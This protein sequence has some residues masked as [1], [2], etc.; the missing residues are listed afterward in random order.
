MSNYSENNDFDSILQ[1]LLNNVSDELDK[2]QGSIIYDALAPAAAELAQAYISLDVY[3][4]QTYLA[5][6]VGESLDDRVADYGVT[7]MAATPAIRIGRTY[8][9]NGDLMDVDIGSRFSVPNENGGYNFE[10]TQKTGAGTYLFTCETTGTDGNEYLGELLPL[11]TIN[12]LGRAELIGTQTPGE[13]EETDEELRN[14]VI[15][16]ITQKSFS[17]N[18]AS[19]LEY[20]N[21]ISGVGISKVFPVWNGGGTVKIAFTTSDYKI[22]SSEF[23]NQIQTLIDPIANQG[24]GIGLAPIGH[25]VTVAAPTRLNVNIEATLDVRTGF[26]ANSLR[27]KIIESLE[28]YLQ[29]VQNE[30]ADDNTLYIYISRVAAAILEVPEVI[31]VTNIKINNAATDLEINITTSNV[32]FPMLNEVTLNE[33]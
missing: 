19:Y 29:E 26:T 2:R 27:T 4:D 15:N 24:Q 22:P 3:T 9:S 32:L 1:R 20:M 17:G 23:I 14:R 12:N 16:I 33:S 6:A 28:K 31:N 13:N 7:R 30:W 10:I 25:T 5:T 8:D 11:M 18:K 21:S